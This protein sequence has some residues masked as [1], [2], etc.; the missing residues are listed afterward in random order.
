MH[1]A[2]LQR[3]ITAQDPAVNDVRHADIAFRARHQKPS[4][5]VR[6]PN[7]HSLKLVTH[8]FRSVRLWM[9]LQEASHISVRLKLCYHIEWICVRRRHAEHL[10]DIGMLQ[11][12]PKLGAGMQHLL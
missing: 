12:S 5:M 11:A 2:A 3:V 7:S 4:T 9:L 1:N 6:Y 8:N 10:E